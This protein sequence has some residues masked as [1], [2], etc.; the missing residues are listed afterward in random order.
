MD[1]AQV[2]AV[3]SA[4]ELDGLA[5]ALDMYAAP[6]YDYCHSMAPE[7]AARAV[8]DTFVVAW[9]RLETLRDPDKLYLWLQ[10][11]AGNECYRRMLAGYP[12]AGYPG[13]GDP[14]EIEAWPGLPP[15]LPGQ[16]LSACIDDTPTGRAYRVSVTHRAGP[17]GHDG[18]PKAAE[19]SG[20]WRRHFRPN[21]RLAAAVVAAVVA[22]TA[23]AA[24]AGLRTTGA[25][26]P[27]QA[28]VVPPSF[29]SSTAPGA[30]ALPITPASPVPYPPRVTRS[31][32]VKLASKPHA[33]HV[34][35][36]PPAAPAAPVQ[37]PPSPSVP[38]YV[39][40]LVTL[41]LQ[42]WQPMP[43]SVMPGNGGGNG[44]GNGNGGGNGGGNDNG[45]GN[46]N[47]N[48]NGNGDG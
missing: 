47:G 45:N 28:S 5:A 17:F 6:L 38:P 46:K 21:P 4:G 13:A 23:A 48:G 42:P 35:A 8:H 31:G 40:P 34:G 18:F 11:I 10:T 14:G 30:A 20:R 15:R 29:Q 19:P 25:V 3:I 32:E 41:L 27:E 37:L 24:I 26:R 36:V 33:R 2:V 12:G 16:V 9:C 39:A 1:D 43:P 44:N 22:A 7:F